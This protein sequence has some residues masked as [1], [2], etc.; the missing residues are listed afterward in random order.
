MSLLGRIIR[1]PLLV[2]ASDKPVHVLAGPLRGASWLPGSATHGCWLGTYERRTQVLFDRV[3]RP[4]DVVFDIGAN[5]GFYTLLAA[6]LV[7]PAGKV[8]AF[9]PLPRNLAMLERHLAYNSLANVEIV[10]AAVAER[11][12]SAHFAGGGGP[13]T[14]YLAAQGTPIDLVCLD[15]LV[16][17]ES[18]RP[19]N[20]VKI[21]VEGAESRVLEGGRR[22]FTTHRPKVIL[23]AHGWEQWTLCV[24]LL[25]SFGYAVTLQ[26]DGARDGNY[27]LLAA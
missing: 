24:R 20:V 8:V 7:G 3:T 1:L 10:R 19:P 13:S 9:E 4:G 16:A 2:I 25:E 27:S 17:D 11:S 22:T 18:I 12:G 26:R 14:G 6:R 15:D 5:V 23:A 21:D